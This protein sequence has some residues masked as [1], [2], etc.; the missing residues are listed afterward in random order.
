MTVS[1]TSYPKRNNNLKYV[2]KSAASSAVLGGVIQS[3]YCAKYLH[4]VK[5]MYPQKETLSLA[6]KTASSSVLKSMGHS[7]MLGAVISSIFCLF[8]AAKSKIQNRNL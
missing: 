3:C 6:K 8:Y 4:D 2:T 7:A 1:I 5:K